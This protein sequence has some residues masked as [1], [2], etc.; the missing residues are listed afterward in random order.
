M[1]G[2]GQ[3]LRRSAAYAGDL[4]DVAA[5]PRR[6]VEALLRLA[7]SLKVKQRRGVPHRLL[8]GKTLGLLFQKPSTRTRVSFEA[9]MNQLGGHALSLPMADIQLSRGETVAD[10]ARV[11]SRYLD[12][13]VVRTYD[14]ATVEEW[15]REATMPV[16]NG[17]TDHSHPCQALSD[18]LTIQ[19]IKGRL[20]GLTIAYVGDGN[21]VANSLIEAAAKMGMRMTVGCPVGYQPDQHVV[22][23]ARAEAETTGAEIE[24]MDNPQVAVKEAD[25]VYTDVWIS[26]GRE[27]EQARRLKTLSP[28]Q[29]NGRLL[30]KAKPDAIVMH[31]LPAH[32][33]E[34]IT[35]EVLDGPQ[36]VVIDQAEN[37]LHMQKAI[38]VQL[39]SNKKGGT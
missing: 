5:I 13:I 9:G 36:S 31:C 12:G 20:K 15:A 22:D 6:Q 19:E 34:E 25:V 38:L 23:R 33:G 28:Y 29:L 11:L 2:K 32:R 7:A 37:R 18:L 30:Q 27:R 26:M 4:L 39:L 17:L 35:A 16:I 8:A 24:V 1:A 3:S 10:T 21:N 14:H